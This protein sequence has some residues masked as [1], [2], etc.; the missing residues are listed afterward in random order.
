M[1]VN[2]A[3]CT[4][5]PFSSPTTRLATIIRPNPATMTSTL[6]P[7]FSKKDPMTTTRPASGPTDRSMPPVRITHSWPN[8]MNAVAAMSTVSELRLKADRNRGLCAWV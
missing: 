3:N 7:A 2:L 8:E 5:V 1:G 6:R 4:M